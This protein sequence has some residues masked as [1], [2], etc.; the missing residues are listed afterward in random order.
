M[1]AGGGAAFRRTL[2]YW[3]CHATPCHVRL[4]DTDVC[5]IARID[6][7]I[8]VSTDGR[9]D[10]SLDEPSAIHYP[11]ASPRAAGGGAAFRRTFRYWG[12]HAMSR[13][14]RLV[15]TIVCATA[16]IDDSIDVS[17]HGHQDASTRDCIHRSTALPA[18]S[19]SHRS[20]ASPPGG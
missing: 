7:S 2:G 12:R 10:A 1:A 9:I 4:V 19:R 20:C 14:V 15:D 13:H 16:C 6:L 8:D 18:D 17:D 5:A 11:D 3:G